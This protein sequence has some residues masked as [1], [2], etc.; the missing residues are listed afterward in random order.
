MSLAFAEESLENVAPL[1][2]EVAGQKTLADSNADL[3]THAQA[4]NIEPTQVYSDLDFDDSGFY[5][6]DEEDSTENTIA[7]LGVL[8]VDEPSAFSITNKYTAPR[9]P[10]SRPPFP[11][12]DSTDSAISMTFDETAQVAI[13]SEECP[14]SPLADKA[15]RR[16]QRPT[17]AKLSRRTPTSV[18]PKIVSAAEISR[19]G[20][21]TPT[22]RIFESS[23]KWSPWENSKRLKTY[24]K[25]PLTPK[26]MEEGYIYCFQLDDCKYTKIGYAAHREGESSLQKS[27][28]K[29]IKEHERCGWW[30]PTVVIHEKVPHVYRVEQIIHRHLAANKKDEVQ[31]SK[32]S[33]GQKCKH[34]AHG[35]W[36]DVDFP[37]MYMALKAWKRWIE[38]QPYIMLDGKLRLSPDW[39]KKLETVQVESSTDHWLEWLCRYV[40]EPV[41]LI[42]EVGV[43]SME[44]DVKGDSLAIVKAGA[45]EDGRDDEKTIALNETKAPPAQFR[46]RAS[47]TWP[48]KT[49]CALGEKE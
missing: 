12:T 38:T 17:N 26:A 18:Q 42:R 41:K 44:R 15:K 40:P 6:G 36:F 32:G 37:K 7:P 27:L 20:P 5:S 34:K 1:P 31:M 28:D 25:N 3:Q 11:P 30:N 29:R 39:R 23:S 8:G 2:T 48:R 22:P 13:R 16:N 49:E 43:M 10:Q 24:I 35:E 4:T 47:R 21:T 46:P 19:R 14:G 45:M 9:T 33:N